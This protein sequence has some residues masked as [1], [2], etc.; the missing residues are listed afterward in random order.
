MLVTRKII[1][2]KI[3]NRYDK[4]CAQRNILRATIHSVFNEKFLTILSCNYINDL[5][6]SVKDQLEKDKFTNDDFLILVHILRGL[7]MSLEYIRKNITNTFTFLFESDYYHGAPNIPLTDFMTKFKLGNVPRNETLFY[8][9]YKDHNIWRVKDMIRFKSKKNPKFIIITEK[10]KINACTELLYERLYYYVTG[11][12]EGFLY[13]MNE[14]KQQMNSPEL[15]PTFNLWLAYENQNPWDTT[16][17]D[18]PYFFHRN[19]RDE[20][21]K[22]PSRIV[23][24]WIPPKK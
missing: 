7:Y 18:I 15:S 12:H 9:L 14:L 19:V 17:Y 21:K 8:L 13:L 1:L 23:K 10:P 20:L 24:I 16:R 22:W 6:F 4:C 3:G 2:N 5:K 11:T